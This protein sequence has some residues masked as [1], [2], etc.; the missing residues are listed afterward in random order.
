M[1]EDLQMIAINAKQRA[2]E[3]L[4]E[5]QTK[6]RQLMLDMLMEQTRPENEI[7]QQYLKRETN[8]LDKELKKFK[9]AKAKEK[10]ALMRDLE[11]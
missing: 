5:R 10:E 2:E 6:E 1:E 3:A 11:E 9:E 8:Q 7:V 4:K